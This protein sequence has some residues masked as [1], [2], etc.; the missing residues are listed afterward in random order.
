MIFVHRNARK[1]RPAK[2]V[3]FSIRNT[4]AYDSKFVCSKGCFS[5]KIKIFAYS[6]EYC[7]MIN[8]FL[9]NRRRCNQK[10]TSLLKDRVTRRT[11]TKNGLW[12]ICDGFLKLKQQKQTHNLWSGY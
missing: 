7:S 1:R 5:Q 11:E 8:L 6:L 10:L 2:P 12:A 3:G 9:K 4:F